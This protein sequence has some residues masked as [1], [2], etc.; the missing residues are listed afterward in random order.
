[1]IMTRKEVMHRNGVLDIVM[2]SLMIVMGAVCGG[3]VLA[4]GISLLKNK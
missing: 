4:S 2:G 3:L 1:M